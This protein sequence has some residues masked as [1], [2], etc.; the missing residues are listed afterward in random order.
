MNGSEQAPTSAPE[1][2]LGGHG[3]VHLWQAELD[4]PASLVDGLT[5]TLDAEERARGER[6]RRAGDRRRWLAARAT[7]RAV[8]ARY[9]AG[10][11]EAI[12]FTRGPFGKPALAGMAGHDV[13]FNLS[14]AGC[15]A[16]CAVSWGREVGVDLE[17]IRPDLATERIAARFFP[18]AQAADLSGLGPDRFAQA[19]FACWTRREAYLKARGTGFARAYAAEPFDRS[20]WR[21][22][23]VP[24]RPGY[25]GALAVEGQGWRL[26]HWQW[27]WPMRAGT[28]PLPARRRSAER[29]PERL[30]EDGPPWSDR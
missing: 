23:D 21:V 19:F 27:E 10:P 6:F 15:W 29:S 3:E 14:H 5:R 18:P 28:L 2:L 20:R 17:R 11:P 25:A 22:I 9:I 26:R 13:R 12:R 7:L 8:L 1:G 4:V 30:A 24:V 16:L